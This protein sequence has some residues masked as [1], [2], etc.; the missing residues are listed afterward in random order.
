MKS[1]NTVFERHK[2]LLFLAFLVFAAYH[3]VGIYPVAPIEGDGIGMANGAKVAVS[4]GLGPNPLSYNYYGR[5]GTYALLVILCK[6]TK[7]EPFTL[8]S[9]LSGLSFVIFVIF[10]GLLI[11][12]ITKYP[13]SICS[14]C[15]LMFPETAMGGY[16]ANNTVIAAAFGITSLYLLKVCRKKIFLFLA[17]FLFGLGAWVRL[18]VILLSPVLLILLHRQ[19]FKHTLCRTLLL[20]AVIVIVLAIAMYLS[21]DSLFNILSTIE[22]HKKFALYRPDFLNCHLAFFPIILILLNI[23]GLFYLILKKNWYSLGIFFL[24]VMPLYIILNKSIINPRFMY[25]LIPFFV[26]PMIYAISQIEITSKKHFFFITIIAILFVAQYLIGY[27]V[28]NCDYRFAR[29]LFKIENPLKTDSCIS[30]TLQPGIVA[31]ITPPKRLSSGLLYGPIWQHY[32]KRKINNEL[33]KLYSYLDVH[34]TKELNLLANGWYSYTL[35]NN[36][37]LQ[38]GYSFH[39]FRTHNN[40]RQYIFKKENRKCTVFRLNRDE[41]TASNYQN[42]VLSTAPGP[43]LAIGAICDFEY[44]FQD[45]TKWKKI[46]SFAHIRSFPSE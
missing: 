30:A 5:S 6:I 4:I 1:K 37:L 11:S 29:T 10:S 23:V 12:E 24:A 8:L 13:F 32:R 34:E 43:I 7:L 22:L 14:L 26:I 3:V 2:K 25:Y 31:N 41:L 46:C 28:N 19:N 33:E 36:V 39:K 16:Y 42:I 38:M 27:K 17:A 35:S 45:V 40:I 9:I 44:L 15:V 21:T 18:D 20:G